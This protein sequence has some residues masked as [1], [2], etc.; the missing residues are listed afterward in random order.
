MRENLAPTVCLL[1]E[2]M[3]QGKLHQTV[4]GRYAS[5]EAGPRRDTMLTNSDQAKAHPDERDLAQL[6][7]AVRG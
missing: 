3:C 7:A 6:A 4:R 2:Y 5:M 1:G